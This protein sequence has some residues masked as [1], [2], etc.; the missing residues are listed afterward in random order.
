VSFLLLL[1]RLQLMEGLG[2]LMW[3]ARTGGCLCTTRNTCVDP[4][5]QCRP[6]LLEITPQAPAWS[7]QPINQSAACL[8]TKFAK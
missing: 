3:Y 6:A 7:Y 8:F 5:L 1:G 2:V 4:T